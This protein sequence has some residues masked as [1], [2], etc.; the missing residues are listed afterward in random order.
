MQKRGSNY[1][2]LVFADG[3]DFIGVNDTLEFGGDV[4][5]M[6]F[7]IFVIDN[8]ALEDVEQFSVE[9]EPVPG[10]FP[11]VVIDNIASITITDNDGKL[12]NFFGYV[13]CNLSLSLSPLCSCYYWL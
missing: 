9:I 1:S 8:S 10:D 6:E 3:Q 13:N 4:T 5:Q 7:M 12:T 2:R 11:V